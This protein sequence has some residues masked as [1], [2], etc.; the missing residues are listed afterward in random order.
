MTR[1]ATVADT[2]THGS[3]GNNGSRGL[4]GG[5]NQ[6]HSE[7]VFPQRVYITGMLIALGGIVMFFTALISAWVV[8]RGFPNT[9]W[10]PIALP[11]IVWLNTLILIASSATL[12]LAERCLITRR[13]SDH[14]HWWHVTAILGALFLTGQVL[15][16]RQMF[17]V[18][19]FLATSPS[20][21][22]FYVFTGAHGLHILGG[23]AALLFLGFNDPRR[24]TR[25]ATTRVVGLY[26]HFLAA[27]WVLL[28]ALLLTEG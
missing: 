23:V 21:S 13:D 15:A 10:R 26:W 24:L 8:R 2:V 1:M 18:G 5:G 17:T 12:A 14:R 9:D 25:E 19:L 16:W 28:F 20:S 6:G 4:F 3:R 22:F 27:L 7:E 11:G